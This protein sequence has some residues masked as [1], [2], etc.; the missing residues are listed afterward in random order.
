MS[1]TLW[2][3]LSVVHQGSNQRPQKGFGLVSKPL[4]NIYR[5]TDSMCTNLPN[6]LS[7][8]FGTRQ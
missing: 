6:D 4:R 1:S 5:K 2:E 3:N 8:R 7:T